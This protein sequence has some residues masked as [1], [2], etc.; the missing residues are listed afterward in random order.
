MRIADSL[1]SIHCEIVEFE[2]RKDE[3]YHVAV[4]REVQ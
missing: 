1:M 3:T 2:C 4:I